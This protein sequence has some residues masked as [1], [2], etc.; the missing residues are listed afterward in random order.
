MSVLCSAFAFSRPCSD[1]HRNRTLQCM[2][3]RYESANGIKLKSLFL[4]TCER[5][6]SIFSTSFATRSRDC[7]TWLFRGVILLIIHL[8]SRTYETIRPHRSIDMVFNIIKNYFTNCLMQKY[9]WRLDS[10]GEGKNLSA[11]M[12]FRN[13]SKTVSQYECSRATLQ[14]FDS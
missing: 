3:E 4:P 6:N 5:M 7:W 9:P 10:K 1:G 8:E 12:M 11:F 2:Q 14:Q 13:L